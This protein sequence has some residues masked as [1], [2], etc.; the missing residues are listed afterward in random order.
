MEVKTTGMY[1]RQT[2]ITRQQ[3]FV[4]VVG[5]KYVVGEYIHVLFVG[6]DCS[7]FFGLRKQHRR[8]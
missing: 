8:G 1:Y 7:G 4:V 6:F 5:E 2:A 3:Q